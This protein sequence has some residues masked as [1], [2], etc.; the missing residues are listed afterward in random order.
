M[1]LILVHRFHIKF[2]PQDALHVLRHLVLLRDAAVVFD[3]EY[4]GVL[5]GVE[6]IGEDG[7]LDYLLKENLGSQR[8]AVVDDWLAVLA[9]PTVH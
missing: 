7:V 3:R 2:V 5:G 8:P 9:I 4:Q 6:C 1:T